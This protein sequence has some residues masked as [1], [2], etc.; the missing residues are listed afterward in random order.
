MRARRA[1]TLL[2]VLLTLG[3][4]ALLATVFIGG[5][6]HL[7]ADQPVTATEVFLKAVQEARKAALKSEQEVRLKFDKEKKQFL[8]FDGL[9]AEVVAKDGFLTE[10]RPRKQ[11]PLPPMAGGDVA[12]DFLPPPSKG[13][14]PAILVGGVLIESRQMKAVTFY[15]DGTCSPFRIQIVRNGAASIIAIDPWTCAPVLT[16]S[17][18]NASGRF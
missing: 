15:P 5:A 13:M 7:M 17:D 10:E 6:A 12:I 14:G 11:L 4:I 8:I 9:A 1:F 3:L 16:A 2:E 18:A